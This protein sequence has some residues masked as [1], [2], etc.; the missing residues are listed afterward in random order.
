MSHA[1]GRRRALQGSSPPRTA[2]PDE[3][4]RRHAICARYYGNS[5]PCY[6]G[7][8]LVRQENRVS[9]D[10]TAGTRVNKAAVH[11]RSISMAAEPIVS[12]RLQRH[13]HRRSKQLEHRGRHP[14]G[15]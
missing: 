8:P 11:A 2:A 15:P 5:L 7:K 6:G 14:E 1:V 3:S 9:L 10:S 4:I 13:V 12:R